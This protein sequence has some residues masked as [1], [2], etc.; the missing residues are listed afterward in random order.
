MTIPEASQLVLQA[1]AIAQSSE[2][3]VLDMGEPVRIE[4]LATT[5]VRL[6]GCKLQPDTGNPDDIEIVVEGPSS[7]EKLYEELFISDVSDHTEVSKVFCAREIWLRWEDL[8]VLCKN[9][10]ASLSL[11]TPKLSGPYCSFW[12]LSVITIQK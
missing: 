8:E 1:S 9:C 6:Y 7:G 12:R 4:E 2:V 11:G 3:F 10:A 5:M